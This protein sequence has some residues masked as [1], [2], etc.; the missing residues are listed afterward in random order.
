MSRI[1]V[2]GSRIGRMMSVVI[3]SEALSRSYDFEYRG[4][5][6][7]LRNKKDVTRISPL[8]RKVWYTV[9]SPEV[10]RMSKPYDK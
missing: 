7:L 8:G 10:K 4:G 3:A 9:D 5:D 1:A 6:M 2:C